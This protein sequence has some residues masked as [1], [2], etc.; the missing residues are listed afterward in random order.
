MSMIYG[1]NLDQLKIASVREQ[2][3]IL[4]QAIGPRDQHGIVVL[5][6]SQR[7]AVENFMDWLDTAYG[8][9]V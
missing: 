6:H 8:P 9:D 2:L 3:E 4:I 5:D 7:T 1:P